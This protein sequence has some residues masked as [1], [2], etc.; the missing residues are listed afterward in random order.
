MLRERI[1][2]NKELLR[3]YEIDLGKLCQAGIL[4]REKDILLQ[5][6]ETDEQ[7]KNGEALYLQNT[8]KETQDNLNPEKRLNS[9]IKRPSKFLF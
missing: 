6:L 9:S 4:L 3:D 1:T 5:D 8:L 2:R 7:T